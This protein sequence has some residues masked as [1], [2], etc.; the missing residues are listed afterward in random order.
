MKTIYPN[1]FSLVIRLIL[2]TCFTYLLQVPLKKLWTLFHEYQPNQD[3][4]LFSATIFLLFPTYIIWTLCKVLWVKISADNSSITFHYFYKKI[5]VSGPEVEQ[6]VDTG[7]VTK[8]NPINGWLIKLKSG[9]TIEV[10]EFN[11]RS[12]K[13]IEGFLIFN[14]VPKTGVKRSWF[15]FTRKV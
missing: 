9:K 15:P 6:Y 1:I 8:R 11:V 3:I 14:K 5:E 7:I 12:R 13:E 2:L 10:S 4:I